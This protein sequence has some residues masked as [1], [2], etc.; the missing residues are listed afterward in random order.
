[1]SGSAMSVPLSS[2][3]N[4]RFSDAFASQLAP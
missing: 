1:M 2:L 3:T 4:Y